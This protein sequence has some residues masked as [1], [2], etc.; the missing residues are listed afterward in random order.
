MRSMNG[1]HPAKMP[2]WLGKFKP[3]NTDEFSEG[4]GLALASGIYFLELAA[5]ELRTSAR[6]I[7]MK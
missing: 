1:G 3:G 2:G 7:L 6:A 5:G 4:T